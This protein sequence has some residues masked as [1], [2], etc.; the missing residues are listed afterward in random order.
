M[1][2]VILSYLASYLPKPLSPLECIYTSATNLLIAVT[3]R[4]RGR[5]RSLAASST[6]E[7]CIGRGVLGS[8]LLFASRRT[9]SRSGLVICWT[10]DYTEDSGVPGGFSRVLSM[11]TSERLGLSDLA[12]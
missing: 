11:F 6:P 3:S 8:G 10:M 9:E 1:S 12:L 2:S 5:G 7:G 4:S